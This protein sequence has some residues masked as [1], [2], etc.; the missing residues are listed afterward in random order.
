MKKVL[1]IVG[2]II[3][4]LLVIMISIPLLFGGKIE[5]IAKQEANKMLN[6]EFDFSSLDISLFKNFPKAS[7]TVN[8][9]WVKGVDDFSNDTIVKA[10][11][12]T[13]TIDIFSL[14]GDSYEIDRVIL[15][16]AT[17]KAVIAENDKVNWDIL[18]ESEV[19]TETSVATEEGG[20]FAL[21]LNQLTLD[22]LTILFDNRKDKELMSIN[23]LQLNLK[24]DLS[25]EHT[26]LNI[27]AESPAISYNV[28]GLALV[29]NISV[30]TKINLDADLKNNKFTLNQN[31][32]QLNAIK[33]SLDGWVA[34]KE[35]DAI[36]MDLS[37]NTDKI[38]F[39]QILSLIPALYTNDFKGLKT[40][41]QATLNAYA[42]GTF[43]GD[44]L[45]AF[46]VKLDI[47]DASFRYP[48]DRKS[49]RLNS[50]HL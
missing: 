20:D 27:T 24:G 16:E 37:I 45:P 41:G 2:V 38:D 44:N 7:L 21:K 22:D 9:F 42:K 19:T 8:N 13:A 17:L 6:G 33:A 5:S 4:L 35:D 15:K 49:T 12:L 29:N 47:K 1:K 26:T 18:K 48:S 39:K 32:I 10:K 50:S 3:A 36:D 11:E 34:L 28:N 25:S 31:E 23:H 43:K 40:E 30:K 14:F 46:N